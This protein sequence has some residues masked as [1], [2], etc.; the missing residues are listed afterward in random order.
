MLQSKGLGFHERALM[1]VGRGDCI[2]GSSDVGANGVECGALM[3]GCSPMVCVS[4][5]TVASLYALRAHGDWRSV[6][7]TWRQ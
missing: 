5:Y 3:L 7:V 2:C 6:V 1:S 4:F